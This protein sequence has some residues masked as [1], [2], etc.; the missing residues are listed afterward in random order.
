MGNEVTEQVIRLDGGVKN[1][2]GMADDPFEVIM[3]R[4]G[5]VS[6]EPTSARERVAVCVAGRTFLSGV[7]GNPHKFPIL[8]QGDAVDGMS[9][10]SAGSTQTPCPR[11]STLNW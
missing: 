5:V 11:R 9:P 6:L 7:Q 1:L 10:I 3:A 2:H 4:L 8:L